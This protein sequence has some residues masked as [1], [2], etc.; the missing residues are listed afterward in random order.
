MKETEIL[1]LNKSLKSTKTTEEL[2]VHNPVEDKSLSLMAELIKAITVENNKVFVCI[3]GID[4]F[5]AEYFKP[6]FSKLSISNN[7][8]LYPHPSRRQPI[9]L[10]EQDEIKDIWDK[11]RIFELYGEFRHSDETCRG[12]SLI[13]RCKKEIFKND[14]DKAN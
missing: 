8:G 7:I 10:K 6:F 3:F 1:F 9:S 4:S 2:Y 5:D 11:R 14:K 13:Y 12:E